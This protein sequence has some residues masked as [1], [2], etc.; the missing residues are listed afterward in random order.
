MDDKIQSI[1]NKLNEVF[2]NPQTEL[3]YNTDFQLLTAIILS[4][5]CTDKRVN[6][7]TKI[8]Y[9][10][11]PTPEKMNELSI[12]ELEKLYFPVAF[13]IARQSI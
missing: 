2:P 8:L 3:R 10:I 4:A 1:L 5:Q 6:E 9:S 12:G 11:A 13:I 7:V